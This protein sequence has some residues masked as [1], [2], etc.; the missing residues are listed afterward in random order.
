LENKEHI[1]AL[2][3]VQKAATGG[4]SVRKKNTTASGGYDWLS[5]A[6]DPLAERDETAVYLTGKLENLQEMACLHGFEFLF[7]LLDIA[8]TE[9]ESLQHRV[10]PADRE[11]SP[12]SD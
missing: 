12:D 2:P 6:M 1:A 11:N 4:V 10:A 5:P 7:Y 3:N 8:R 9:A